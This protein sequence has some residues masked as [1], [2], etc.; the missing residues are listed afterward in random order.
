MSS[1]A[2]PFDHP[3][4]PPELPE[5]PEGAPPP[6]RPP[7]RPAA[8]PWPAWT[9][10]VALIAGFGLALFGATIIGLIGTAI[11]GGDVS[12]PPGGVI[13]AA[14]VFQ[15]AALITSAA[16]LARFTSNA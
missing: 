5:L 10:P 3:G 8:A 11:A 7:A 4:P 14:T 1:E 9:A 13:I 16:L 12:D 6:R 2:Y 15:D